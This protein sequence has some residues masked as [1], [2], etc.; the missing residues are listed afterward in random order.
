MKKKRKGAFSEN[1]KPHLIIISDSLSRTIV[2]AGIYYNHSLTMLEPKSKP[3]ETAESS[4]SSIHR[5]EFDCQELDVLIRDDDA[6]PGEDTQKTPD[7]GLGD[8]ED[9][10]E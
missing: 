6:T 4:D 7:S 10:R 3:G 9:D 8:S 2:A 1:T 5:L